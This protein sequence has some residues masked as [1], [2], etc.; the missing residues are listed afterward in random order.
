MGTVSVKGSSDKV[1]LTKIRTRRVDGIICCPRGCHIKG[2][3][4]EWSFPTVKLELSA[5]DCTDSAN[6]HTYR[7]SSAHAVRHGHFGV[8]NTTL[9]HLM[10]Y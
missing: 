6:S 8:G 2:Q 4:P 7:P 3:Q 10:G 1:D 5:V 9:K